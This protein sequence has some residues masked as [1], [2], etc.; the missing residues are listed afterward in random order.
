LI[1]V[2]RFERARL[3]PRRQA[4]LKQRALQFAEKLDFGSRFE[5]ARLRAAP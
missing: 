1:G 5:G 3:Q 2:E 4:G